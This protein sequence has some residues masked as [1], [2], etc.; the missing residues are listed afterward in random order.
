MNSRDLGNPW[1]HRF[2]LREQLGNDR[3]IKDGDYP[4][5]WSPMHVWEMP[6]AS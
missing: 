4:G 1:E 2:S 6:A 3:Q 5:N